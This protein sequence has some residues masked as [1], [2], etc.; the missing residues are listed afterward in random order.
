M[1]RHAEADKVRSEARSLI[2][3]DGVEYDANAAMVLI[4]NCG[5][6][7]P[8]YIRLRPVSAPTTGLP[9][10]GHAGQ[11][12]GTERGGVDLLRNAPVWRET[13]LWAMLRAVRSG[14]K[15]SRCNQL[16]SIGE[17]GGRRRL[18]SRVVPHAIRIMVPSAA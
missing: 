10:C 2:T 4:A 11:Q 14:W 7:I 9:T 16:G 3:I 18:P 6:V 13:P 17:P 15:P 12:P 1:S 5:E 8:P